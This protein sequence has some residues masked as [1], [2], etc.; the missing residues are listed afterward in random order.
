MSAEIG[1]LAKP[2][3]IPPRITMANVTADVLAPIEKPGKLWY[4]GMAFSLAALLFGV[5]AVAMQQ[6]RGVGVWG[7]RNPVMWAFD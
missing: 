4:L 2:P 1:T 6:M 5:W 3:L 7:L